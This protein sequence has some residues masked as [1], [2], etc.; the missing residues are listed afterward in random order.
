[1]MEGF[2][3]VEGNS[4][5]VCRSSGIA[6]AHIF[7]MYDLGDQ[8]FVLQ[9]YDK[10]SQYDR[11]FVWALTTATSNWYNE[12]GIGALKKG[13]Q[14]VIAP[15]S[16]VNDCTSWR[17]VGSEGY[18]ICNDSRK[19]PGGTKGFYLSAEPKAKYLFAKNPEPNNGLLRC[20]F[21]VEVVEG[22]RFL[23][24]DGDFNIYKWLGMKDE[25]EEY[26]IRRRKLSQVYEIESQNNSS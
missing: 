19:Q 2:L 18:L 17:F 24:E 23:S 26:N 16:V 20:R 7:R 13:P 11:Y 12:S 22:Q 15:T 4:Y 1:M 9:V 14:D 10:K 21:F 6:D 8:S 3:G 5:L 25:A